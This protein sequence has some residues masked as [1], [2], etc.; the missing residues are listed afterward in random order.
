MVSSSYKSSYF[1]PL[2]PQASKTKRELLKYYFLLRVTSIIQVPL[3]GWWGDLFCLFCF[4]CVYLIPARIYISS[5][6]KVC[7]L[8]VVWNARTP[9]SFSKKWAFSSVLCDGLQSVSTLR[10][11]GHQAAAVTPPNLYQAAGKHSL[12]AL[13]TLARLMAS[14]WTSQPP[15]LPALRPHFFTQ[16]HGDGCL[17][18]CDR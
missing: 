12:S 10:Q 6:L 11:A 17:C 9:S 5:I 4:K 1:F 15:R 16:A 8:P 3:W 18:Q 14:R 7:A 13:F 2:N